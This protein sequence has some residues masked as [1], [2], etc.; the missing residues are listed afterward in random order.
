MEF[1]VSLSIGT[2]LG[3][4]MS[5]TQPKR[6]VNESETRKIIYATLL[7]AAVDIGLVGLDAFSDD[8][9]TIQEAVQGDIGGIVGYYSGFY[10]AK[11]MSEGF[12]R[13]SGRRE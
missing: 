11:I 9:T 5:R 12:E 10:L 13:F 6:I 7:T 2:A 4:S 8:P 3:F 1:G